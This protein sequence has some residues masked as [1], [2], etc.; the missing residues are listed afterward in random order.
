MT[1]HL[2]V[3]RRNQY[4]GVKSCLSCYGLTLKIKAPVHPDCREKG[5]DTKNECILGRR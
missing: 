3:T 1:E 2:F 5:N 4:S